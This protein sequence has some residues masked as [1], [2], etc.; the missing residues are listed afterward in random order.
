MFQKHMLKV[1]LSIFIYAPFGLTSLFASKLFSEDMHWG[2]VIAL[3]H[4]GANLS[5]IL[6]EHKNSHNPI[7]RN[8][9]TLKGIAD[10]ENGT[11]RS[12]NPADIISFFE[13]EKLV[14]YVKTPEKSK[15]GLKTFNS[16]SEVEFIHHDSM[17]EKVIG[18]L[19]TLLEQ[20]DS[21][22]YLDIGSGYGHL[23]DFILKKF[24][25]S[26]PLEV[27]V[28][29][30]ISVQ[31]YMIA[32]KLYGNVRVFPFELFDS[33][34]YYKLDRT[35]DLSTCFNV[36]HFMQPSAFKW[37]IKQAFKLTNPGG[38]HM[39]TVQS[40]YFKGET[41]E[42][43]NLFNKRLKDQNC[44]TPGYFTE[45][46]MVNMEDFTTRGNILL[47]DKEG[48]VKAFTDTGFTV[49][50]SG[51]YGYNEKFPKAFC[52]LIAQKPAKSP[53]T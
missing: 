23:A 42:I 52:Y 20:S 46:D 21:V 16:S 38:Y 1:L 47:F 45:K 33:L 5:T 25:P 12:Y 50:E 3:H 17:E 8:C 29:E 53:K 37:A 18:T 7:M 27:D 26:K 2:T 44:I 39:A 15:D 48:F 6:N 9:L 11:L 14:S 32:L 51:Y 49:I 41:S 35:Y 22:K 4:Q 19:G 28:C 43:V 10:K 13:T 24:S 30:A 31:C 36:Y 40:V 34:H